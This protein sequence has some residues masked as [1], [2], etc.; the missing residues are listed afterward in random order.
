M[1]ENETSSGLYGFQWVEDRI[2]EVMDSERTRLG[3]LYLADRADLVEAVEALVWCPCPPGGVL[4][5]PFSP[6]EVLR[7]AGR[8]YGFVHVQAVAAYGSVRMSEYDD[9]RHRLPFYGLQGQT[10]DGLTIRVWILDEGTQFCAL[11]LDLL[12]PG[13][14]PLAGLTLHDL[15]RCQH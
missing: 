7:E 3:R 8:Q 5:L 2:V 4:R 13:A 1:S 9:S 11:A 12:A 10:E 15:A 14:D 6:G